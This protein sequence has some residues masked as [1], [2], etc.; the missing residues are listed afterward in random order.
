MQVREAANMRRIALIAALLLPSV[1]AAELWQDVTD[2][3]GVRTALEGRKLVYDSGAWQDFRAS[4]RTL[5]VFGGRDSWGYWR[6]ED[7]RYCSQWP[8]SDV[9]TCYALER[10]GDRVRFVGQGDDVTEGV[11]AD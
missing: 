4:G 7:D 10:S 11:Y 1:A 5:Y 8:P 6:V 9:W 2:E 3:A